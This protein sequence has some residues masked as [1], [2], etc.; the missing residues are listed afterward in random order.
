MPG[1]T[2]R[3]RG[4]RCG[5]RVLAQV[6]VP[7]AQH[8]VA[9]HE[10]HGRGNRPAGAVPD[11]QELG[12][13]PGAGGSARRPVRSRRLVAR[14]DGAGK[15][16]AA[17]AGRARSLGRPGQSGSSPVSTAVIASQVGLPGSS[18]ASCR[19]ESLLHLERVGHRK[20]MSV[21]GGTMRAV[22][23]ETLVGVWR[24][25]LADPGKSWALFEHGTCVVLTAPG[26]DLAEEA[27]A[28]PGRSDARR[29]RGT[30]RPG[31]P[32]R[33]TVRTGQA[34]SGRGRTAGRARRGQPRPG[35]PRVGGRPRG[36]PVGPVSGGDTRGNR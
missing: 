36:A 12:G 28:P 10:H 21:G 34:A 27:G 7:L 32:G 16:P 15:F 14:E 6:V 17:G 18:G 8:L 2:G 26:G 24:R 1:W 25:L 29:G 19:R 5:P 35:G 20:R 4:R 33:R 30:P 13:E 31:R 23:T 3:F 9:D 22:N 11:P